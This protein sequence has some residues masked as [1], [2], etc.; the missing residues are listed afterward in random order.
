MKHGTPAPAD[1][2]ARLDK[3]ALPCGAGA[4]LKTSY[5]GSRQAR[6][7]DG[8]RHIDWIAC[9]PKRGGVIAPQL[10]TPTH[11]L[12]ES[13]VVLQ[14]ARVHPGSRRRRSERAEKGRGVA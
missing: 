3:P 14:S 13:G 4:F 5:S 1:T 6:R 2:A 9:P 8:L 7:A 11:F 12:D 10:S